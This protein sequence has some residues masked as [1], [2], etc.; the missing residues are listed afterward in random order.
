M[1]NRCRGDVVANQSSLE[2]ANEVAVCK[3]GVTFGDLAPHWP[4][5]CWPASRPS[6][7]AYTVCLSLC[8][9]V[10]VCVCVVFYF[11]QIRREIERTD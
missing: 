9:C 6:S 7:F 4:D 8:V 11:Q 3:L 5:S 10:C 1:R 2:T